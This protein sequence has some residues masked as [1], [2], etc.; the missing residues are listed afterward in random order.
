MV[1]PAKIIDPVSGESARVTRFGQLITAPISYSSVVQESATVI[2]TAYNLLSPTADQQIVVTDIIITGNR[3]I[4]TNDATVDLYLA[5]GPE[6]LAFSPEDAVLS[7]EIEKN[8][9]LVLTGLNLLTAVGKWI[10][11][12]TDDNIVYATLMYYRVPVDEA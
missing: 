5:D 3:N 7:L 8:G 11:F 4:G 2:N 9:K 1:A 10:N 6:E 12:K